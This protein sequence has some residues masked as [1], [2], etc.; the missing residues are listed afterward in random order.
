MAKNFRGM[1][2]R[3]KT[4]ERLKCIRYRHL[5]RMEAQRLNDYLSEVCKV[6]DCVLQVTDKN[7]DEIEAHRARLQGAA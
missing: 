1:T 6:L 4:I 7:R 3:E 2:T 5:S